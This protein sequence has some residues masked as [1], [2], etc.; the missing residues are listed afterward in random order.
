MD[1]FPLQKEIVAN[2]TEVIKIIRFTHG[3]T[4]VTKYAERFF[5]REIFSFGFSI[6]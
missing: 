6:I 3:V 1:A 4:Q 2:I 5:A